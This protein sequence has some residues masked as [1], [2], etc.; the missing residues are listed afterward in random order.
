[1]PNEQQT[2]QHK[3][4]KH[5]AKITKS[6]P[7]RLENC[8]MD[9][10]QDLQTDLTLPASSAPA[11]PSLPK[12]EV[13]SPLVNVNPTRRRIKSSKPMNSS[14]YESVLPGNCT[15]YYSIRRFY[16]IEKEKLLKQWSPEQR[17]KRTVKWILSKQQNLV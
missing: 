3:K 10:E 6:D 15:N 11:A 17:R 7:F 9:V 12:L 16:E 2:A 5:R 1:M 4:P 14:Q 8:W 13:T